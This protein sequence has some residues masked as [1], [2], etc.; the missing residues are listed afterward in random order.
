MSSPILLSFLFMHTPQTITLTFSSSLM[1]SYHLL[2]ATFNVV[3]SLLVLA[4]ITIIQVHSY[5]NA[6]INAKPHPTPPG[7]RWGFV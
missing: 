2:L 3:L 4:Y 1:H 7:H 6:P 5:D